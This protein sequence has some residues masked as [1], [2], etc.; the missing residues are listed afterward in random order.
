MRRA[1]TLRSMKSEGGLPV[2][3]QTGGASTKTK[4][5]TTS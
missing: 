4:E 5:I 1:F 2:D 3:V